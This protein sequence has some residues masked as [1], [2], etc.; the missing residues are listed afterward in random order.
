MSCRANLTSATLVTSS[1]PETTTSCPT[2]TSAT[3]TGCLPAA[4]KLMLGSPRATVL[5]REPARDLCLSCRLHMPSPWEAEGNDSITP[6]R[7]GH[8]DFRWITSPLD[9]K[10]AGSQA[11]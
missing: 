3:P 9:H 6:V 11:R 8:G 5:A 4:I 2:E 7:T 10:P 1:R